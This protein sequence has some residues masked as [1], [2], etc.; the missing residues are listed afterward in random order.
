MTREAATTNCLENLLAGL[1]ATVDLHM[2]AMAAMGEPISRYYRQY[3]KQQ[4]IGIHGLLLETFQQMFTSP[5]EFAVYKEA[6]AIEAFKWGE[7]WAQAEIPKEVLLEVLYHLR[8]QVFQAVRD[9][10]PH[11]EKKEELLIRLHEI[12]SLRYHHTM[13][14]YLTYKDQQISLLHQQK[15]GVIG[16]MAAGMAHE[17][18]NPLTAIGGFL[19]LMD[20]NLSE[21]QESSR[22]NVEQFR[23][24]IQIC[25]H[26]VQTLEQLVTS[27]LIL[28]RKNESVEMTNKQ[29]ELRTLLERVHK[30]ASHYVVEKDVQLSFQYD[31]EEYRIWAI[32]SYVEQI[33]LNLIK[34][35][36]DAVESNGEVQVSV[37]LAPEENG[38]QVR[39]EDNGCGIPEARIKHLF[40]PFYTTKEKGTGMGLSVCK[41]LMEEMGGKIAVQSVVGV[42]TRIDIHFQTKL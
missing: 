10:C 19:Q 14:G 4:R 39:V 6:L 11:S 22:L 34:N 16:Q 38:V 33:G 30:L 18:R 9:T 27:F 7:R 20:T 3:Q 35:A 26:E 31:R 5:G 15:I 42:G 24:Y 28:A 17:I 36:V 13:R 41:Q 12:L 21:S 37:R 32:P 25:Q 8:L 29:V 2:E 23:Q 1:E 40:E